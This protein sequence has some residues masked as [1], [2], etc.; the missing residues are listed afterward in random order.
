MAHSRTPP[1]QAAPYFSKRVSVS[2]T[3][4]SNPS[5][6]AF[7]C[8]NLLACKNKLRC[9][10]V[11]NQLLKPSR[12]SK[13]GH[14]AKRRLRQPQ[15]SCR[16]GHAQVAGKRKLSP[17]PSAYP[18]MA[19]ITGCSSSSSIRNVSHQ[20]ARNPLP[21]GKVICC[22]SEISAPA[23]NAFPS[24]LPVTITHLMSFFPAA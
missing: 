1:A 11:T 6:R 16:T 3:A 2:Q 19:A 20:A 13:A 5:S 22:I 12:A 18:F 15:H 17:P 4:L 23:A 21:P 8:F 7:T 14:N 10:C 24:L 9:V